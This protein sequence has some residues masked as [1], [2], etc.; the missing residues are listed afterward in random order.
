MNPASPQEQ[1]HPFPPVFNSQSRLLILGTFPSVLSRANAFYYGNPN[2]RFWAVLASLFEE[3]VPETVAQKQAFLLNHNIALWDVLASC[4]IRGSSDASIRE[5]TP[6]D[7]ASLLQKAPITKVFANGQA[8]GRLYGRF[9]AGEGLP[10][11]HVLPST[12]PAN[13]AW[14]LQRLT[15]AWRAIL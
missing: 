6:N 3:N 9:F 12:S 13:A 5:A 14:S 1:I 8:A 15:D 4:Q 2:N 11:A 10:V 7:I